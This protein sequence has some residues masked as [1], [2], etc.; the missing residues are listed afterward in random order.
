MTNTT[1]IF[2]AV[3]HIRLTVNIFDVATSIL[4]GVV[5]DGPLDEEHEKWLNELQAR[6]VKP[7]HKRVDVI[8]SGP[9]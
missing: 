4:F 1:H 5:G 2:D 8:V 7:H 6:F 9:E 3:G